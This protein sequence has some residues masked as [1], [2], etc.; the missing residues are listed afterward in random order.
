[1]ERDLGYSPNLQTVLR[2]PLLHDWSEALPAMDVE[3]IPQCDPGSVQLVH[4]QETRNTPDIKF[5]LYFILLCIQECLTTR[6]WSLPCQWGVLSDYCAAWW[7]TDHTT[8]LNEPPGR[9]RDWR[10]DDGRRSAQRRQHRAGSLL[11][12]QL[13]QRYTDKHTWIWLPGG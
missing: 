1:M 2:Y 4:T 6:C 9:V 3:H 12:G 13:N 5:Y 11:Q 7:G 10:V 8:G